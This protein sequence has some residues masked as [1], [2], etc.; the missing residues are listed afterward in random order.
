MPSD[1]SEITIERCWIHP[2]W[3]QFLCLW[4]LAFL[5]MLR[6]IILWPCSL[7]F[8]CNLTPGI[9]FVS[10]FTFASCSLISPSQK[11][12]IEVAYLLTVAPW[13]STVGVSKL[14]WSTVCVGSS[15]CRLMSKLFTGNHSQWPKKMSRWSWAQVVPL[16]SSVQ[17]VAVNNLKRQNLNAFLSFLGI[18]TQVSYVWK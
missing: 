16:V 12:L 17:K 2:S 14:R 6:N 1:I 9:L 11:A 7:L 15:K 5:S 18:H 8:S 10:C 4:D 3:R 13:N